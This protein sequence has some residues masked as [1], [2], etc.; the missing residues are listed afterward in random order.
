MKRKFLLALFA[1]LISPLL[2][3]GCQQDTVNLQLSKPA[4]VD[5]TKIEEK[6]FLFT[7]K[8]PCATDYIFFICKDPSKKDDLTNYI[9][10]KKVQQNFI[11]VTKE[12]TKTQDYYYYVQTVDS[13][14]KFTKSIASSINVFHNTILLDKPTI[15][16]NDSLVSWSPINHASGYDI[17]VNE[18]PIV[19]VIENYFDV[20][21]YNDGYLLTQNEALKISI[22]ATAPY[23]DTSLMSNLVTYNKHLT[24]SVP[25]I[26]LTNK[27]LTIN[28][29]TNT[30]QYELKIIGNDT[31]TYLIEAFNENSK[32]FDLTNFYD[33]ETKQNINLLENV[34]EYQIS[35][36]SIND[37]KMSDYSQS[38]DILITEKVESPSI[39]ST[40]ISSINETLEISLKNNSQL[41]NTLYLEVTIN[42]SVKSFTL[43]L[44]SSEYTVVLTK[45][46]LGIDDINDCADAKISVYAKGTG[47]YYLDSN[48]INGS[49]S[50]N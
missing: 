23:Y 11:D 24:P 26:S 9:M 5:A 44:E 13:T 8:N 40:N 48:I 3:V 2:L 20:S 17:Y 30:K 19:S 39:I 35:V 21:T 1:I 42:S 25:T 49:V 4:Y 36:R 32:S 12:F 16:I 31:R 6:I 7:D 28:N 15:S 46:Q 22:K 37:N 43:T 33:S 18:K 27:S 47:K 34:G 41:T 45:T 14:N 29:T 10:L 50:N 38:V